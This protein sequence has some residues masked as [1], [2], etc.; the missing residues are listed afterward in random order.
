[1]AFDID[2]GDAAGEAAH[3]RLSL[4]TPVASSVMG[5]R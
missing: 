4:H 1:M 3:G 5:W 2:D